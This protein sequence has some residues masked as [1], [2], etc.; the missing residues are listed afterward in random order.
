MCLLTVM[1]HPSGYPQLSH[2][3][4]PQSPSRGYHRRWH[5]A[6]L[7]CNRRANTWRC[8]RRSS[9]THLKWSE[10]GHR[11]H[12]RFL[13]T[14]QNSSMD[15]YAAAMEATAWIL[16]GDFTGIF[17]EDSYGKSCFLLANSTISMAISNSYVKLPEGNHQTW[18]FF[19]WDWWW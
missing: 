8:P 18:W 2:P 13:A 1:N 9:W 11:M 19:A 14:T 12:Q 6:S 10:V 4:P 7:R 5:W 3:T 15:P 16:H 17:L